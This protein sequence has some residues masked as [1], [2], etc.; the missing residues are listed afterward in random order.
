MQTKLTHKRGNKNYVANFKNQTFGAP[1]PTSG[2]SN[3][4]EKIVKDKINK[5]AKDNLILKCTECAL[6]NQRDILKQEVCDYQKEIAV[7]VNVMEDIIE[8]QRSVIE[9]QQK[10]NKD[11]TKEVLDWSEKYN[12]LSQELD[13][14]NVKYSK[15]RQK[16]QQYFPRNSNKRLRRRDREIEKL[17]ETVD[18]LKTSLNDDRQTQHE[19]MVMKEKKKKK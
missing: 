17:A 8:K 3:S 18:I 14:I 4:K 9:S 11:K 16:L 10:E 1:I 6:E 19:I 2:P 15:S 12:K 5:V 7:T 13:S